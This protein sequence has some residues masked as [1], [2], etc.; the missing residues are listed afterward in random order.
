M[1][2]TLLQTYVVSI[3]TGAV[4]VI[5]DA[6][7]AVIKMQVVDHLDGHPLPSRR[8]RPPRTDRS[9][10]TP[11][12]QSGR[13]FENAVE[14]FKAALAEVSL[15]MD[16]HA[17]HEV[18]AAAKDTAVDTLKADMLEPDLEEVGPHNMDYPRTRWP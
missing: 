3:N 12:V 7:D 10:A 5:S 15:P 6:W 17:L 4:M 11:T 16:R 18:Y 1:L 13:A 14:V 8:P 2:A 9:V